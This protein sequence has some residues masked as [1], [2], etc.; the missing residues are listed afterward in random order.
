MKVEHSER[1]H[2]LL[3]ASGSERWMACTPSARKEEH[4]PNKTSKYAE[5]GT[6][7]HELSELE[8][9][10]YYRH[11]TKDEYLFKLKEIE[12]HELYSDDM[13]EHVSVYV[14]YCIERV[15]HYKS[16]CEHVEISIE[17]RIDLTEYIPEGFGSNDFVVVADGFIEVID[18][19]YGMGVRVSATDNPQLKLYGLGSVFRHRLSYRMDVIRL[20]IVQP[21]VTTSPSVFEMSVDTLEHWAETE[22][23][24]KAVMAHNGEGEFNPGSWCKWCRFKPQCKALYDVNQKTMEIDFRDKEAVT[25]EQII[26][27]YNRIGEVKGWID[28]IEAYVMNKLMTREPVKGFKLVKG[29]STRKIV[30]PEK[31]QAV[32]AERGY[33]P[34][35]YMSV[36]KLLGVT[37]LEKLIT[38]KNVDTVIGAYIT[39]TEPKATIAKEDDDRDSFFDSAEDDFA[40]IVEDKKQK[41]NNSL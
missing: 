34:E 7:A 12:D 5:E 32:L 17:E 29:R 28:S 30:E 33:K 14:Q 41:I 26:E 38:K 20:A 31:V 21:R 25:E 6:L 18:L 2:S 9:R 37:A 22:V 15:N 35:E 8:L 23:R 13:P 4:I 19:K 3:S 39:K 1:A 10:Y 36:P 40:P 27:A 16:I 24:P 11:I